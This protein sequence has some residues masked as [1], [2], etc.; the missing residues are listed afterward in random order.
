MFVYVYIYIY[1]CIFIYMFV[2]I[3]MCLYIYIYIYIYRYICTV[4]RARSDLPKKCINC[5]LSLIRHATQNARLWVGG[6]FELESEK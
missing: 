6:D 3:Y 4:S 5:N 1:V 2:Y